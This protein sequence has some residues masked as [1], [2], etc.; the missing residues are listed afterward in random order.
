MNICSKVSN[1]EQN[2]G[3]IKDLK[4]INSQLILK[5]NEIDTAKSP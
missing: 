2:W 5:N 4:K 1:L 3:K